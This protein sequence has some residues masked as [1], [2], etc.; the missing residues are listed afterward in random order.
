MRLCTIPTTTVEPL[1]LEQARDFSTPIRL[2]IGVVVGGE[3]APCR[4]YNLTLVH[5][6]G[7]QPKLGVAVHRLI[8]TCWPERRSLFTVEHMTR[9]V[10][11]L[12][13]GLPR[14]R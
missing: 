4:L 5:V 8:S 11:R 3:L 12:L 7:Y 6:L 14:G 9:N 10:G 13:K 1:A 2:E